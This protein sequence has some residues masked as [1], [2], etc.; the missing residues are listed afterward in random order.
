MLISQLIHNPTSIHISIILISFFITFFRILGKDFFWCIDD[1]EGISRFSERW[2]VEKD[3]DGKVTKE[4]KIDSYDVDTG[5]KD[6]D[7]KPITKNVKFLSFIPEIGFPGCILRFLRL[8][9]GKVYKVLGT[10]SKGHEI[11]GYIQSPVRHHILSMAV[12]SILLV[13][14]Y[15]FLSKVISPEVAFYATLLYAVNP[16]TTQSVA[17]ISG[18]NYSLSMLFSLA[19]FNIV[20]YLPHSI[21]KISLV[22]IF[23]FL[24]TI[25]LYLG[26]LS[27]LVILFLGFKLE[28]L[29]AGVIG[30]SIIYWKG[31]ETR[32]FRAAAFKEQNMD[33]STLIN[34]RK[35]IVM[36]KTL[37]Y[38]MRLVWFPM[39]MGLYHVWGYF[40]DDRIERTDRMFYAGI[41]VLISSILGFIHGDNSIRLGIVWFF[42]YWIIFSNF[43]TAQQFVADRYVT[44]A[45]LGNCIIL[46]SIL[47]HT[48]IIFILVGMYSMRSM[49]HINT[50][51]NE[52]DFYLSNF[53]NFRKSEVSL[54]NLGV[55]YINQGMPGAAVD[56]WM[57]STR[58]NPLYDVPWYNLY[59]IFKGNGRLNEAKQFLSKCLDSRVVHFEKRWKE[60]MAD[61]DKLI[62]MQ[63]NPNKRPVEL[64]NQAAQFFNEKD[65]VKERECLIEFLK[66]STDGILPEMITQVKT[67]LT[68][69]D[70]Q[71]IVCNTVPK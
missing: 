44:I 2:V 39:K 47:H 14:S 33:K 55:A 15:S 38:Y 34:W 8:H 59:S 24:S 4:Q 40:Y 28:A 57:L 29:V 20:V 9:V 56:T 21:L 60:E 30:L 41:L 12:Q 53:L 3:K 66:S 63:N 22:A 11:W 17:W 32:D 69:I 49:I 62:G 46:S 7:G 25:A 48:P 51:R 35:P 18:I 31:K 36:L 26:G 19:M 10:N 43:I 27:G 1:I 52:L 50:F 13:L 23:S 45:S 65:T 71:N 5:K 68:Q 58:I 61:L 67:R 54:G 70:S 42:T 16:L 37:W 64:Y 6:K